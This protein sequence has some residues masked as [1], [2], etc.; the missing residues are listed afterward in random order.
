MKKIYY[1]SRITFI[2]KFAYIK[3][4]WFNS[5]GTAVSILIYYFLWKLYFSLKMI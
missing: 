5:F 1:L 3:A 4:F 2:T